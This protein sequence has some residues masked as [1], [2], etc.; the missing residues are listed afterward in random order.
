M[1]HRLHIEHISQD[2][3]RANPR[4]ARTHDGRQ[5]DQI[6]ASIQA[7]GFTNP[8]LIDEADMIIA[9]HGRL[10]AAQRLGLNLL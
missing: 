4:N 7:F 3:I 6:A 1:G 8:V 5:I 10:E 2:A 9:G